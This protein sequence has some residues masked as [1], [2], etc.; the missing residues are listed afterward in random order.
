MTI[1]TVACH[2]FEH[3]EMAHVP[4][5]DRRQ[6]QSRKTFGLKAQW[7]A[8]ES[9]PLRRLDDAH[10]CHALQRNRIAASQG[11]KIGPLAVI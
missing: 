6:P 7:P 1:P 3:H 9:D 5:Q 10:E 8:H 2:A 4:V 11:G